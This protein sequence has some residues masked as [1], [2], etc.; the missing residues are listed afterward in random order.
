M[1]WK[2]TTAWRYTTP[3]AST[4]HLRRI[5]IFANLILHVSGV[6]RRG[7]SLQNSC[8]VLCK[9]VALSDIW[10]EAFRCLNDSLP[11]S[12]SRVVRNEVESSQSIPPVLSIGN[13]KWYNS[14]LIRD[15]SIRNSGTTKSATL[16]L[17]AYLS[18]VRRC[19][20]GIIFGGRFWISPCGLEGCS[21][22][23]L[24][25][26][27]CDPNRSSYGSSDWSKGFF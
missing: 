24:E 23:S 21:D 1:A 10:I 22:L 13:I 15:Q 2:Y 6:G 16:E 17:W 3:E 19:F 7:R 26:V 11:S 27:C 18:A 20:S 5:Q 8:P 12:K 25:M 9:K 4:I 14:A